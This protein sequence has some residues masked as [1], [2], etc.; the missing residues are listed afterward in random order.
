MTLTGLTAYVEEQKMPLIG[1]AVAGGDS[2]KLFR[3]QTG[4]KPGSKAAINLLDTTVVFADGNN[5]GFSASGSDEFTQRMIEVGAIKI[6]KEYCDKELRKYWMGYEV[7]TAATRGEGAMPFEEYFLGE[8]E[9]Q[10]I[11]ANEKAIWKGDTDSLD[12]NL[13]KFD[14]LIKIAAEASGATGVIVPSASAA[15]V[16]DGIVEVVKSI[17][18][19]ILDSAKIVLGAD[20]FTALALELTAKNLFH[21]T[22]ELN[23]TMEFKFPGTMLTVKAVNGLNGTNRIYAAD[24]ANNVFLG[25]DL[26]NDSEVFKLY[27]SEDADAYRLKVEYGLGV[28]IARPAEV[29]AY[30]WK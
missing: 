16:Y 12:A 1:K 23:E 4:L 19:A 20:D 14:G 7:T 25:T 18:V 13:N 22:G 8:V 15:T 2:A 17:P 27:F 24:F 29:V 3:L 28:Q 10:I 30:K 26:E 11:F 9:K 6:N 5:C 21:Y